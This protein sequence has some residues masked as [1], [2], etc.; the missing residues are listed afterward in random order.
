MY[1]T[2]IQHGRRT[3]EFCT[4]IVVCVFLG[5][6]G[7]PLK[8]FAC[9]IFQTPEVLPSV[10]FGATKAATRGGVKFKDGMQEAQERMI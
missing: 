8:E 1:C 6:G 2:G 3:G 10:G 5:G 9:T 4:L 7:S